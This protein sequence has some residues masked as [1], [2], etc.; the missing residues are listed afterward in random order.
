MA[1]NFSNSINSNIGAS[2][3][4][5]TNTFTVTNPSDT[6]SSQAL[7]NVTVGGTTAGDAFTT[8]TV[9]GTTNW[10]QGIDN[11]VTGDPFV[12]A[13]STALGTTNVMSM[14][15]AGAITKPLQ[16]AFS[17]YL[18]GNV[19]NATGDGT[20]YVIAFDSEKY[21]QANNFASNTFT[22]PITGIY[23]FTYNICL[24]GIGAL[25]TSSLVQ[26]VI[27]GSG[28]QPIR[29]NPGVAKDAANFLNLSGAFQAQVTATTAVTLQVTVSGSTKTITVV[30]AD[31]STYLQ[32]SLIC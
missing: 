31:L 19:T 25:H 1:N 9:A 13:A 30:G 18:S 17:A 22:S 15:T 8:Y 11:S 27:G 10:S 5:A 24:A 32:G 14:T 26:L 4:G 21:D 12:I 3:S 16:P 6:A 2:N 23:L 7:V 29:I 20:V 28:I